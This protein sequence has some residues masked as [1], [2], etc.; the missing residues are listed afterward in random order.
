MGTKHIYDKLKEKD[1]QFDTTAGHDHDGTDSKKVDHSNL[2]GLTGDDHTQYTLVNGTRAFTGDQSM[3]NN[4]LTNV[5]TPSAQTDAANKSYVDS[6]VQGLDWQESVLDRYDPTGG[7]PSGVTGARYISTATANGWT[8]NYIYEYNGSSWDETIPN[9]GYAAWVEDE[10]KLYVYNG[11]AWVVFGSTIDHGA[12]SGL[13]DDDHTQYHNDTR[14][15][16]RYYQKTEF[17]QSSAGSGDAGKPIKLDTDGNVDASMIN[18]GDIDHANI[19]NV[20]TNTHA[21]I[22]THISAG[23]GVHGVSGN[24]VG[25]SDVQTLTNKTIDGDDN[26]IQDVPLAGLKAGTQGDLIR[27]GSSNWEALAKGTDGQLLKMVSGAPAW[28]SSTIQQHNLVGTDHLVSGE[29]NGHFLR[30][31]SNKTEGFDLMELMGIGSNKKAVVSEGRT[32]SQCIT[33]LGGPGIIFLNNDSTGV[34]ITQSGLMIIG[35]SRGGTPPKITSNISLAADDCT[36]HN[37]RFDPDLGTGSSSCV[38][39]DG[40]NNIVDS[41]Y[42]KNDTYTSLSGNYKVLVFSTNSSDNKIKN[43]TVTLNI[44]S[45]SGS[46]TLDIVSHEA[47]FGSGRGNSIL[48]NFIDVF[49]TPTTARIILVHFTFCKNSRIIGNRL[50]IESSS[51]AT[52]EACIYLGCAGENII[53]NNNIHIKSA[54]SARNGINVLTDSGGSVI[55]TSNTVSISSPNTTTSGIR[56]SKSYCVIGNNTITSDLNLGSGILLTSSASYCTVIGNIVQT[57]TSTVSDSGSNNSII[58]NVSATPTTDTVVKS[59]GTGK[60]DRGWLPDDAGANQVGY[61]ST[62]PQPETKNETNIELPTTYIEENVGGSGIIANTIEIQA[63]SGSVGSSQVWY[64]GFVPDDYLEW[65]GG[66]DD[67]DL[68]IYSTENTNATYE[69]DII[70]EDGTILYNG[71]SGNPASAGWNH[72]QINLGSATDA[73]SGSR[74]FVK[75]SLGSIQSTNIM[76]TTNP[77]LAYNRYST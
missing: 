75:I 47:E 52:E 24:V 74:I 40:N 64:E 59:D 72:V 27:M 71:T 76:R 10:N 26:T 56:I 45:S 19:Q 1:V 69:I 8:E 23:S 28:A 13:G 22:D 41:C 9:E 53:T 33:A 36:L 3:G 57:L 54:A 15:D 43:C 61:I 5:G 29:A 51:L 55:V 11:S 65:R 66:T 32:L 63:E 21:Q 18:D 12:L 39:I 17:I 77:L 14:G 48:N 7:L 42:F 44:A 34:S 37:L 25:T 20:G 16:A 4:K 46:Y 60:I 38:S 31:D 50:R 58:M 62:F 6:A 30:V 68:Y 67:L 49:N 2:N 70:Q 35:I 73:T